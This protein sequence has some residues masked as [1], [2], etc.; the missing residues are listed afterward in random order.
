MTEQGLLEATPTKVT[1]TDSGSFKNMSPD[2]RRTF[3]EREA[4]NTDVWVKGR[5]FVYARIG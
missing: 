4:G 5:A 1:P 3:E 2:R